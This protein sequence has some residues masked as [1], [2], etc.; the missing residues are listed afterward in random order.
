[1]ASTVTAILLLGWRVVVG[2]RLRSK[3]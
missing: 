1:V 2:L 3:V